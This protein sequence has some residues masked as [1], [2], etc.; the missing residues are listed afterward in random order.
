MALSAAV[1][2][3]AGVVVTILWQPPQSGAKSAGFGGIEVSLSPAGG[4]PGSLAAS[5][6]KLAEAETVAPSEVSSESLPNPPTVT[7]SEAIEAE[8][9]AIDDTRAETVPAELAK[10]V[11]APPVET[12]TSALTIARQP[13]L[14]TPVVEAEI[15]DAEPDEPA[16]VHEM[17]P[18]EQVVLQ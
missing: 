4:A 6:P 10:T 5:V 8:T 9:V 2:V 16:V 1:L 15:T 12:A 13:Q 11:P 7:P 3:H 17:H 18:N 14:A